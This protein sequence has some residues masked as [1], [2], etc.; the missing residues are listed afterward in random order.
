MR[1][2]E[3]DDFASFPVVQRELS[4]SRLLDQEGASSLERAAFAR[5]KL[6]PLSRRNRCCTRQ[7]RPAPA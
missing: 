1:G 5:G 2:R 4:A 6:G 3:I 7:S